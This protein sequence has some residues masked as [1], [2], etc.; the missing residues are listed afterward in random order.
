MNLKRYTRHA[1]SRGVAKGGLIVKV[2]F[3]LGK[4]VQK[5]VSEGEKLW[6]ATPKVVRGW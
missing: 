1:S 4:L 6:G 2:V 5:L 3:Q